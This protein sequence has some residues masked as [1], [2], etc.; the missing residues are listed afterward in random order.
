MGNAPVKDRL[1]AFLG[2]L[3]QLALDIV[4]TATQV[5]QALPLFP[6][7]LSVNCFTFHDLDQ[8][9]F[10]G[11]RARD[12]YLQPAIAQ[13]TPEDASIQLRFVNLKRSPAKCRTVEVYGLVHI[14]DDNPYLIWRGQLHPGCSLFYQSPISFAV[15]RA[16]VL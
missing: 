15:T 9:N 12:A 1:Y 2:K 3:G 5:L 13:L 14:L 11:P 6:E 4:Y 8:L 7:E 16:C 10:D